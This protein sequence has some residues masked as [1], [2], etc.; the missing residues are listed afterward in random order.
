MRFDL[1][2]AAVSASVAAWTTARTGILIA[3]ASGASNLRGRRA[4]K[5]NP[6]TKLFAQNIGH[7]VNTRLDPL[8][9]P[10]TCSSHVHSVLGNAKFGTELKSRWFSDAD[11][12][13]DMEGKVNQTTSELVPNLSSYWVPSLYIWHNE[14]GKHHLVPSFAR[15]YYR[16]EHTNSDG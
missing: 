12:R 14:T 9:N 16:I 3:V 1:P 2:A 5:R 7:L 6:T 13:V 8:V 10:G 15:T 11:W 4:L